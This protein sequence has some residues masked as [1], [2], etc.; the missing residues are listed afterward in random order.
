M[1]KLIIFSFSAFLLF[2]C[3]EE[4][5]KEEVIEEQVTENAITLAEKNPAEEI[6]EKQNEISLNGEEAWEVNKEMKP[7]IKEA[8]SVLQNY[9]NNDLD[10]YQQLAIDLKEQNDA[11]IK[12]CTMDGTAHDELHNWLHPHLQ[13]V[14]GL[15]NAKSKEE[16]QEWLKQLNLS[17]ETYHKYFK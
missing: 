4:Q 14:E 15:K 11:L 10:D 17:M 16:S 2:S 12:S 7:Y 1:K 6:K 5:A 3:T 9:L 13:L 8:E